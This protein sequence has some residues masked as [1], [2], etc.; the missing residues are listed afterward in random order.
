V[1][2]AA[3]EW[4]GRQGRWVLPIGLL[5]GVFLPWVAGPSRYLLTPC[6]WLLLC[7]ATVRLSRRGLAAEAI[8]V[9]RRVSSV[10]SLIV[11]V[12]CAQLALPVAVFYVASAVD[13]PEVWRMA[14]TLVAA[15]PPISGAPSLVLLLRGDGA[16]AL[17]WLVA[18]TALLPVT[19]LP[20]LL[21]LFSDHAPVALVWPAFKLLLLIASATLVGWLFNR[22]SQLR[23]TYSSHEALDGAA[24]I[25]LAVMVVGLMSAL[26][27]PDTHVGDLLTML[28]LA[29]AVN[30]GLQIV[31]ASC[32]KTIKRPQAQTITAGVAL[33]NRNVALY[34]TVL[35]ASFIEPLLLFI[36][37]YQIPMYLTPLLGHFFYRRSGVSGA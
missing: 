23:G 10:A 22:V 9:S 27:A 16:L 35:P 34:L 12:A 29:I 26:H 7:I 17:R 31:G 24:A 30:V 18:G 8:T 37:C 28:M 2:L 21:L 20:A 19:C 13:L 32:A 4:C 33:G 14:A 1:L 15:A 36:A 3:L 5:C 6:I 11:L 25:T